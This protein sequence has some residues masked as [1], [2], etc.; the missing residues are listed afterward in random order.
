M[1]VHEKPGGTLTGGQQAC[2]E[3]LKIIH[4]YFLLT[5]LN[6]DLEQ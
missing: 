6:T 4:L 3:T 5:Y 1:R 2:P